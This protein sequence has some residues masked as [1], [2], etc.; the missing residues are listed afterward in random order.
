MGQIRIR[1]R[2]V[3]VPSGAIREIR[4]AEITHST[5]TLLIPAEARIPAAVSVV[6]VAVLPIQAEDFPVVAEEA[7]VRI[8]AVA[9]AEVAEATTE[10]LRS[11]ASTSISA[12]LACNLLFKRR[13]EP[14]FAFARNRDRGDEPVSVSRFGRE[15]LLVD[16]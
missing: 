14:G 2:S 16:W 5:R 7:V 4:V 11:S 8:R 1:S 6:E 13:L 9:E 10:K 12:S 15:S 3:M